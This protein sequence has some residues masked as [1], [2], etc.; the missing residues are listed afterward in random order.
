MGRDHGKE[1]SFNYS[2]TR[3]LFPLRA[4]I[5]AKDRGVAYPGPLAKMGHR[6]FEREGV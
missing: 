4:G 3:D 2:R 6:L 5:E 1:G